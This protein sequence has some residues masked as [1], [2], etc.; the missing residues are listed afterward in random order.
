MKIRWQE[1]QSKDLT[2]LDLGGQQE[3]PRTWVFTVYF[4]KVQ[5]IF[6]SA[7]KQQV[8]GHCVTYLWEGVDKQE[9]YS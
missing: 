6:Q 3:V 2:R 7:G 5:L 9:R 4:I 1:L 8:Q